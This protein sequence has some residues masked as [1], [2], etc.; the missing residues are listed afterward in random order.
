M[1]N[2]WLVML[3]SNLLAEQKTID[4]EFGVLESISD[5]YPKIV[6]SMDKHLGN[7]N[8]IQWMNLIDFLLKT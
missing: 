1:L 7:N 5:N 2:S 6:L 3:Q 4:R 8:G